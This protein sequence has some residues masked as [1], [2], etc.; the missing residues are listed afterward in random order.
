[1]SEKLLC[2]AMMVKNEAR[3]IEKTLLSVKDH[4]D[5]WLIVDTGSKDDTV[6]I[7]ERVMTGLPGKIVS[8]PFVDYGTTRNVTLDWAE[9]EC[10]C[11]FVLMLSGNEY[12]EDADKLRAFLE[13]VKDSPSIFHEAFH[14]NVSLGCTYPS[15]RIT[16]SGK[17]WRYTGVVHEYISKKDSAFLPMLSTPG[18]IVHEYWNS[19]PE[20]SRKKWERDRGLLLRALKKDS[21]DSRS[22]FYLAQT[23]RCLGAVPLAKKFYEKRAKM[24][25]WAPEVYEALYNVAE[26]TK[27]ES[28]YLKAY[29][30]SPYRAEPLVKLAEMSVN[31]PQVSYLYAS[32]ACELA[33]PTSTQIVFMDTDAY[34]F[35][36]WDLLG[37]SAFY[38]GEYQKGLEAVEE[39]LKVKPDA[40]HLL[41]NLE[42][43]RRGNLAAFKTVKAEDIHPAS[44]G[45]RIIEEKMT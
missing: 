39:A 1:M 11:A 3:A 22:V 16:R 23:Y 25:G 14:T 41:A 24:G 9:K 8:E 19:T 28:D 37:R 2:L 40:P 29:A 43:Y 13:S 12:V 45:T 34:A 38:V 27:K 6:A 21:N 36:R 15:T 10:D 31:T 5:G 17:D 18:L 35:R 33:V 30:Q 26:I 32:R 4:I 7:V 44:D 42:H 20:E